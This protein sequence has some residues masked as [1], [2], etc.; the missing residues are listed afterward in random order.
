LP[1]QPQS[2]F[3]DPK[4]PQYQ[5]LNLPH[6]PTTTIPSFPQTTQLTKYPPHSNNQPISH[7]PYKQFLQNQIPRSIKIQQQIATL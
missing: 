5:T 7:Q 3:S 1:T 6:L 4:Q 2:P